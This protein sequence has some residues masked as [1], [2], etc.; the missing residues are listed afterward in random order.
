MQITEEQ[1]KIEQKHFTEVWNF[2]KKYYTPENTPDYWEQ[3]VTEAGQIG[4][5]LNRLGVNLLMAVLD[6]LKLR[7]DEKRGEKC[8]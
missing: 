6:E 2:Y 7:L 5:N 1:K 8:T 4:N 3:A